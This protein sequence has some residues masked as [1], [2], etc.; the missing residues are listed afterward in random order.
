VLTPAGLPRLLDRLTPVNGRQR[1]PWLRMRGSIERLGHVLWSASAGFDFSPAI[2][3]SDG[4][5]APAEVRQALQPAF[6]YVMSDYGE[7]PLARLLDLAKAGRPVKTQACTLDAGGSRDS[8]Y[9]RCGPE[10]ILHN[11]VPLSLLAPTEV[12]EVRRSHPRFHRSATCSSI[13]NDRVHVV[14]LDVSFP[15]SRDARSFPVLYATLENL[16]LWEQMFA[17]YSIPVD[18]LCALR[19]GGKSGGV[20]ELDR[21]LLGAIRSSEPRLQPRYLV[22]DEPRVPSRWPVVG[23]HPGGYGAQSYYAAHWQVDND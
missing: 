14:A 4:G 17:R 12:G 18:V 2:D 15:G 8:G 1:R 23:S 22:R 3:A 10:I 16:V 13:P 19:I 11:F 20:H 6:L 9:S 7:A 21:D 5:R